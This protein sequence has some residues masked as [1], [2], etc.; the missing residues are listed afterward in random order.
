MVLLHCAQI[1]QMSNFCKHFPPPPQAASSVC[2][3]LLR[4]SHRENLRQLLF[5]G[6]AASVVL[7]EDKDILGSQMSFMQSRKHTWEVWTERGFTVL[8]RSSLGSSQNQCLTPL[9]SAW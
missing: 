8:E 7:P 4:L 9:S 5:S 2:F 1:L 3:Q 6:Q